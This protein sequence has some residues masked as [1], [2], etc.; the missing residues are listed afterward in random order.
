M[1]KEQARRG[2]R[3][4][5]Q[6]MTNNPNAMQ[7]SCPNCGTRFS[8]IIESIIDGGRNPGAKARFLSG[9]INVIQCPRCGVQIQVATPLAYHDHTKELLLLYFPMEMNIPQGEREKLIGDITRA[10]SNSLPPEQRKG[11]LLN[12]RMVLT[13]QKMI[14]T[15][16]EK[17]GI[18]PEMI[19][20]Q[21]K[22]ADLVQKFVDAKEDDLEALVKQ[23]DASLD[24]IF[25]Q[26]MTLAAES[27]LAQGA[28]DEAEEILNRRDDLIA[29]STFGQ[30]AMQ[31]SAARD[32]IIQ[33]VATAL[34][35]MGSSVTIEQFLDY[36]AKVGD[37][38]DH[39]QALVGLARPAM[40][41]N[42][43]SALSQR[44]SSVN[45][46]EK[47]KLEGIRDRLLHLTT[48]IDQQQ[49]V[50]VQ[51]ARDT[52]NE[53]FNA[54]DLDAA[55]E[56][57]LPLIDELFLQLLSGSIQ[58]AEKTNDLLRSARLKTIHEK[59]MQQIQAAAPPE[60]QFINDLLRTE[61]ELEAQMMVV[62]KASGFD[63]TLLQYFD[64]LID[65]F[66][67]QE[68]AVVLVDRLKKLRAAA[69]KIISQQV[70]S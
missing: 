44:I 5:P 14:E 16:L 25:F 57:R 37:S 64:A 65:N 32:G 42:F 34:R 13:P 7:L 66:S 1:R 6:T 35:G 63:A 53:I 12:P 58:Q 9:Q 17:D 26:L 46:A 11:Y 39:L 31:K 33:E 61:D 52:L 50:I 20:E 18:T 19:A 40:D 60:I 21:R 51:Q 30:E 59:V 47:T 28:R 23:H 3:Q 22:K 55:I 62:E 27:A 38:D 69:E 67:G 49:Q 70:E 54:P 43:F 24:A 45:G 10:I 2:E 8:A 15:V 36:I 56:E 68:N 4:T 48:A 29:L 41:Y